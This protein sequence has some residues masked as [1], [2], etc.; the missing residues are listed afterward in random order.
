[1]K[2]TSDQKDLD[3]NIEIEQESK[4]PEDIAKYF[5]FLTMRKRPNGHMVNIA[6]VSGKKVYKNWKKYF[7]LL[8]KL[9]KK[10]DFSWQ[11][12]LY[13]AVILKNFKTREIPKI[14]TTN[15]L[16]A[17]ANEKSI[18]LQ[19]EKIYSYFMKS[20]DYIVD[21]CIQNNYS[22]GKEFLRY[23]IQ[24]NKLAEKVFT[25]KISVYYLAAI[26]NIREII[27]SM[28]N[29]SQDTLREVLVRTDKLRSDIQDAFVYKTSQKVYPID[30][31]DKKLF[32]KLSGA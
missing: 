6:F 19:H 25:G 29:I 14:V 1:M 32:A 12:F 21:Q 5:K 7:D 23:L 22:S 26:K 17:Y 9:S 16:V 31:T 18:K 28:D 2:Q 20:V 8:A 11:D 15:T 30:F 4:N 3:S 13:W 24:S 27:L 10:Y